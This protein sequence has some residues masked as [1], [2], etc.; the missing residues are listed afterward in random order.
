MPSKKWFDPNP[1]RLWHDWRRLCEVIGERRAGTEGERR[2]ADTIARQF[3]QIGTKTHIETFPCTALHSA[4]VRT[5]VHREGRWIDVPA[6]PIVGAPGTPGRGWHEGEMVWLAMPEDLPKLRRHSLKG[7]IAMIFGPMP[8]EPA[9]HR[10]LMAAGP[11][12]AVQ[13]DER[14]PFDWLKND[15]CYPY[16]VRRYGMC[17]FITVR[18]HDAWRW[19]QEGLTRMR[20]AVDVEQSQGES[21]NVIAELPGAR[22]DDRV[23]VLGAHHDTQCNNVGADDNASGVVLLLE[24]ARLLE[25][26]RRRRTLRF[27]TFG[28]E[29]QLSVG[30]AAY[31]RAHRR[32]LKQIGMM[33]N[34][35]SIS[36]PLGHTGVS[37]AAGAT[38]ETFILRSLRRG[39]LYFQ[40]EQPGTPFTDQFSFTAAGVPT[41]DFWRGNT[42]GGRWQHH[43]VHDNL[44]NVSAEPVCD[45][46]RAVAPL[47]QDLA[48]MSRPPF[49]SNTNR[50]LAEQLRKLTRDLYGV[51]A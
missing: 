47:I 14:L 22:P 8:T 10:R 31:V 21:C 49:Q 29:E 13:I 30:S 37:I 11:L 39:G 35:D 12:A 42:A 51:R 9:Q 36:S 23:I 38:A 41:V 15:G 26:R 20:L 34:F 48:A 5:R 25:P 28:T 3:E 17:P 19:R 2:A 33:L 24:L 46:V 16:W 4:S 50:R 45:I 6:N 44:D 40:Q 1:D 32:Q 18:Y 27:V 43:S 7:R